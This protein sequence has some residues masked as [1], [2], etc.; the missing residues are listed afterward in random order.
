MIS[1]CNPEAMQS[2]D[3]IPGVIITGLRVFDKPRIIE[4]TGTMIH[5]VH[6]SYKENML[7]LEFTALNFTNALFNQ[8]AYKL[9]G[10]DDQW[11]YCGNKQTATFTNLNGGTYTFWVKAANNDGVWNQE[12][13]HLTLI[14]HPPFWRT[15]W[16]Y[17]LC[18][19]ALFGVLYLL[20]RFRINQIMKLEQIRARISR[21][22]HDDIG[23][24]LSSINMISSMAEQS[25]RE[26]EKTSDLFGT[27]SSASRQAME[28]MSDIVWSIGPGNDRVEMV[29][30]RMRQYASEI[31]EAAGIEFTL[32][33]H[34]SIQSISLPSEKRKDFYLIFKEAIN[35][36]A[37]YSHAI[38][39]FIELRLEDRKTLRLQIFDDGV[40]FDP[41]Q[42][43][44]GNG[45]KNMKA[46]ALQLKAEISIESAPGQG[47]RICLRMPVV[48]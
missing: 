27:I 40:G 46:R 30:I 31:L 20:Y 24:T 13:V 37:K 48:P 6:L 26:G 10:F 38:Q 41:M 5:P 23:S 32:D 18:A 3:R 17:A 29:I 1:L 28:L 7:S 2:N 8:Y 33:F 16:F 44:T 19:V 21:D 12:G 47:T 39:L 22:L 25:T 14:V 42:V 11:I 36:A 15:W 45:L 4:R 9:E 43:D 35:N 34:P